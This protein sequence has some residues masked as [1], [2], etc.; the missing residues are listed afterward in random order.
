MAGGQAAGLQM[1]LHALG[2]PQQAQGVGHVA[3]ALA[4]DPGD[5]F[6]GAVE[7]LDHHR[8]AARL[9]QGIEVGALDVLDDGDLEHLQVVEL[10]HQGRDLMQAGQLRR[11]PAPLAGDDLIL[12]G[13]RAKGRTRI[14]WIT[15]R[16]RIESASSPSAS[17]SKL[18]RGWSGLRRISSIGRSSTPAARRD[19]WVVA[20]WASSSR[21]E[22]PRPSPR[23]LSAISLA[24]LAAFARHQLPGQVQIGLAAGALQIVDQHRL[25]EGGRLGDPHV[26]RDHRLVDL[27]PK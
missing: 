19:S 12:P 27:S 1:F 16:S 20:P 8:V 9:F 18:R 6:L 22:S 13:R 17:A 14:G 5:G 4:D 26:A 3:A 2:Q 7:A 25:A 15:P 10:A 23:R 21:A 11:A 24:R